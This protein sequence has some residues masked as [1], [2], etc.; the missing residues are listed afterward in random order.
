MAHFRLML[1][2][3][4]AFIQRRRR[5][6]RSF[7]PSPLTMCRVLCILAHTTHDHHQRRQ[8]PPRLPPHHIH[9]QQRRDASTTYPTPTPSSASSSSTCTQR[10]TRSRVHTSKSSVR[11]SCR[12][13]QGTRCPPHTPHYCSLDIMASTCVS[14]N[15]RN[16]RSST[17][18]KH[19]RA[20]NTINWTFGAGIKTTK[21]AN[22]VRTKIWWLHERP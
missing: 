15:I 9:I 16:T 13:H 17:P 12:H 11:A 20:H 14:R 19:T 21:T 7:T 5:R 4:L 3:W 10:T 8:P 18:T 6:K 2:R 22:G 1:A